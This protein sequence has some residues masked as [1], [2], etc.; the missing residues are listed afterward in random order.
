MRNVRFKAYICLFLASY[1]HYINYLS[2]SDPKSVRPE[3]GSL[4]RPVEGIKAP[5]R[6]VFEVT[7][8]KSKEGQLLWAPEVIVFSAWTS[9]E[10]AEEDVLKAYRQR[11][12]SEQ[13]HAEFK[14]ELDIERLP[15]GKF[16]V[17]SAFLKMGMLVY[18]MFKVIGQ[19][20]VFAKALGLKKATRRR[21]KTIMRSII[22][23]CGRITRHARCFIL[24]LAC[25]KPWYEFFAGV[26][27]RLQA[28]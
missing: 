6:M 22:Y 15:S 2:W 4:Y 28:A 14:S 3:I 5:V 16:T 10:A 21:M 26:M 18:N 27:K 25:P 17:N 8:I 13:Y 24:Q 7:E 12:T 19:D 20:M 23:M 1:C 9:L 11:G